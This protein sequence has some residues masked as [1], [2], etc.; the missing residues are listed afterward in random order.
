M[1]DSDFFPCKCD[2]V[3]QNF[4]SFSSEFLDF[5]LIVRYKFAISSY[6]VQFW[7]EKKNDMFSELRVYISQFWL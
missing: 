5:F 2:Y 4:D 6:K 1:R 7:G 3:S